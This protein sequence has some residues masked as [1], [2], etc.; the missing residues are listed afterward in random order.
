MTKSRVVFGVWL[1]AWML[2]LFI[3]IRLYLGVVAQHV[4][5]YPTSGQFDLCIVF[6]SVFALLNALLIIFS[7]KLHV[8]LLLVAFFVQLFALPAFFFVVSG[9]I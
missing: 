5:G 7:R 4:N 9:G 3:G 2:V 6:P 8:A 1:L